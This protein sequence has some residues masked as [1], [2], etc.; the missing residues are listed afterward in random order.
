M[1]LRGQFVTKVPEERARYT[2]GLHTWKHLLRGEGGR[3]G[4]DPV[5]LHTGPFHLTPA[6]LTRWACFPFAG[7]EFALQRN[8][9]HTQGH[10]PTQLEDWGLHLDHSN[11]KFHSATSE[12]ATGTCWQAGLS[13]CTALETRTFLSH[14]HTPLPKPQKFPVNKKGPQTDV[15]DLGDLWA[16]T[17][18]WAVSGPVI[19]C[20][21]RSGNQ[22][23]GT[24]A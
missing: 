17:N 18:A 1:P 4:G 21:V 22:R 24:N 23:K 20:C 14:L 19:F 11:F 9:G 13:S 6:L 16:D 8:K 10:R 3:N 12:A 2:T 5:S 15:C 7:K